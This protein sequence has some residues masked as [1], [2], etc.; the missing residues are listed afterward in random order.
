MIDL[1]L[2][3]TQPDY[4]RAQIARL[5]AD[6]PIDEIIALDEQ[7]RALVAESDGLKA[8]RNVGSKQVGRTREPEARETLMAAMRALGER[9]TQLDDRIRTVDESLLQAQLRVPNLPAEQVPD[10]ASED[11]NVVTGEVGDK[12]TFSFTP[13]PHWDDRRAARAD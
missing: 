2:I 12:R 4:V 5:H 11:D 8:E 7:R 1:H 10:G 13:K 3:R 6:A 9:I